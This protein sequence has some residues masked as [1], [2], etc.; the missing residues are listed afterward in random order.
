MYDITD[1]HRLGGRADK[2]SSSATA[3]DCTEV[4]LQPRDSRLAIANNVEDVDVDPNR[5]VLDVLDDD[6]RP[7][8]HRTR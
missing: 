6:A 3:A 8:A 4:S 5:A 7:D 2:L 1:G